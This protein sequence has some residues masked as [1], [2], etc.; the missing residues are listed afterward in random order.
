M[1]FAGDQKFEHL[2]DDLF[3][4]DIPA[5]DHDPEHLFKEAVGAAGRCG[6]IRPAAPPLPRRVF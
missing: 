5:D 1:L 6:V 4:D 3:G 2:N